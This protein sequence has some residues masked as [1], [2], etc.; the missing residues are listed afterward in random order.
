MA[1]A[2]AS[3]VLFDG[4][5]RCAA[6]SATVRLLPLRLT[7]KAA[8]ASACDA[9]NVA[10]PVI[11]TLVAAATPVGVNVARS[12]PLSATVSVCPLR[13][14]EPYCA[15]AASACI[16]ATVAT[17][18]P[19]SSIGAAASTLLLCARLAPES[20]SRFARVSSMVIGAAALTWKFAIPIS[21]SAAAAVRL[22]G[23]ESCTLSASASP[24]AFPANARL[25]AVSLILML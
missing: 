25:A 18:L 14:N 6:V 1:V 22:A 3:P 2:I 23:A 15:S 11:T 21:A 5:S 19:D 4:L 7:G 10:S 20:S 13:L 12:A 16:C 24:A 17:A 8:S 9:S